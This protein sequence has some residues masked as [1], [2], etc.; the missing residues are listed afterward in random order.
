MNVTNCMQR[1]TFWDAFVIVIKPLNVIIEQQKKKLEDTL[2]ICLQQ[3][4]NWVG[5]GAVAVAYIE[6]LILI[7]LFLLI[8]YMN[9]SM[10]I[11]HNFY[12]QL[13]EIIFKNLVKDPTVL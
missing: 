10:S 8:H 7:R 12:I 9:F 2:C 4:L 3:K 1:G 6:Q 11:F 5:Y 13:E